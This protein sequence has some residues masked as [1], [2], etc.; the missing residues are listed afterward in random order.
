MPDPLIHISFIS[1]YP[2]SCSTG[3]PRK[4]STIK[5]VCYLQVLLG[6]SRKTVSHKQ[7][8]EAALRGPRDWP[9]AILR[10]EGCK[11]PFLPCLG[12]LD[13]KQFSL[14]LFNFH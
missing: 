14:L 9:R 10:A 1:I 7:G 5:C 12:L 8:R 2:Y 6:V 3:C 11:L 13:T 4:K